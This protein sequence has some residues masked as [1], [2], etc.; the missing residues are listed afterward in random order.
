MTALN[1]ILKKFV[2]AFMV[3]PYGYTKYF[4]ISVYTNTFIYKESHVYLYCN[5][6]KNTILGLPPSILPKYIP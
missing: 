5:A 6:Q 2:V 3:F 4:H 1:K